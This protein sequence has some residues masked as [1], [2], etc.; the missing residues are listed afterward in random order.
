MKTN[1]QSTRYW[2]DNKLALFFCTAVDKSL[3]SIQAHCFNIQLFVLAECQEVSRYKQGQF[4]IHRAVCNKARQKNLITYEG[5][6]LVIS[7]IE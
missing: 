6:K 7:A 1:A 2:L 5:K 4:L 3:R